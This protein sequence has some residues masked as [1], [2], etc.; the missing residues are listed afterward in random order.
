MTHEQL[1]RMM[2]STRGFTLQA[3]D[4]IG[5]DKL[6]KVPK[7]FSNNLLW[8]L[9]HIVVVQAALLYK[10]AHRQLPV[11]DSYFGDFFHGTSPA[12]WNGQP[13]TEQLFE[14]LR[15]I[16]NTV[17]EDFRAGVFRDYP[18]F[19]LGNGVAIN[20]ADEV[21][22]YHIMHEGI[23]LGMMLSIKKLV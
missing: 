16:G 15:T 14:L 8:H 3:V 22:T 1:L 21:L 20:D 4:G 5:R 6:M 2:H 7:G 19:T 12:D 18:P 13:D 11:P 9:G 23:H 10:R 17:T